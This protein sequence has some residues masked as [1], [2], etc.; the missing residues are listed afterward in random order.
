MYVLGELE[1]DQAVRKELG[2]L[3]KKRF[4]DEVLADLRACCRKPNLPDNSHLIGFR[5]GVLELTFGKEEVVKWK[6]HSPDNYLT[7]VFPC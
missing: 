3:R 5:N 4:T 7:T 6:A 1:I 2:I